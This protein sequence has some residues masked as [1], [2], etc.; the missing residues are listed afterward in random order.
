LTEA[1]K[2]E[3]NKVFVEEECNGVDDVEQAEAS[4]K[5]ASPHPA[6]SNFN[7]SYHCGTQILI[8]LAGGSK[9]AFKFLLPSL[10]EYLKDRP[11]F[12]PSTAHFILIFISCEVC[13]SLEYEI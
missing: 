7:L 12:T 1:Q 13:K 2:A 9:V 3:Y 4:S 5:S 6:S 11:H 8:L 10:A